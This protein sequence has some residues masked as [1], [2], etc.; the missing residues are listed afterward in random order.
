MQY[1]SPDIPLNRDCR[2]QNETV[3][4]TNHEMA[5]AMW[6]G[7]LEADAGHKEDGRG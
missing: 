1:L 7:M 6:A 2:S 3:V 5:G 4:F